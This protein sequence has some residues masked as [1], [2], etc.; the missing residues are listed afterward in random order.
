MGCLRAYDELPGSGRRFGWTVTRK[1]RIG[2]LR[3]PLDRLALTLD[4]TQETLQTRKNA[5]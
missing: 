1:G 4:P 5:L 2:N 3:Q